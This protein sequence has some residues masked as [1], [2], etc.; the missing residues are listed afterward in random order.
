MDVNESSYI[1]FESFDRFD[2]IWNIALSLC[3]VLS[4][5]IWA[6]NRIVLEATYFVSLRRAIWMRDRKSSD[7][8]QLLSTSF[9]SVVWNLILHVF[10][11]RTVDSGGSRKLILEEDK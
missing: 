5:A 10:L 6:E 2:K 8:H 7:D 9:Q 4:R 1:C 11:R 3:Q